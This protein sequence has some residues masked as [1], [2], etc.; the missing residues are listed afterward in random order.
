MTNSSVRA[1]IFALV[2]LVAALIPTQAR[3]ETVTVNLF[4]QAGCPHCANA[5]AALREIASQVEGL[6]I[7]EIELGTTE[8]GDALFV[9]MVALFEAQNP[10]VLFV[11]IGDR[12]VIDFTTGGETRAIYQG[13]TERCRQ[14]GCVDLVGE[15][16]KLTKPATGR[17]EADGPVTDQTTGALLDTITLPFLGPILVGDLSLPLLTVVL[18]AIDGFNPCAMWVLV[19][20]IGLLLGVADTRRMWML[21]PS[22]LFATGAMYFAVM[23]AWLNVVLLIGTAT[24]LRVAIGALAAGAGLYYLREYW[25]NPESVCR[26]TN[27]P[28]GRRRIIDAFRRVVELPSWFLAVLGIASLA[29]FVNMIELVCSAGVPAVYTQMLAMH[30]L[31]ATAFYSYLLLYLVI[32]LLDDAIIFAMAMITLRSMEIDGGYSRTSHLIGGLVLR[33]LGGIMLLRPDWLG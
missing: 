26:V 13:L 8:E 14:N 11:V 27:R 1:L 18:A 33:G 28:G 10:A 31:T 23:A 30:D 25:T 29:V 20:L 16:Q 32:F 2:L 9:K 5:E 22:V 24:W 7:D 17:S 3:S 15:M 19:L 6:H 21:G 12:H 4:W